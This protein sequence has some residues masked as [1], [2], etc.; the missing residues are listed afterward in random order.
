MSRVFW[1]RRDL[2]LHDNVALNAAIRGATEDDDRSVTPLYAVDLDE[3][4]ALSTIR[5]H[6][7]IASL[8]ALG[9]EP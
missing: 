8:D 4:D 2:R 5:Q 3:F 9:G 6:S 1:F 7:L